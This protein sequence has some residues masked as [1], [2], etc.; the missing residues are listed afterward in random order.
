MPR[1]HIIL[2]LTSKYGKYRK[3]NGKMGQRLEYT[4]PKKYIQMVNKN[5]KN[6]LKV[7]IQGDVS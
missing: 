3:P 7:I 6:K 5:M 1:I 4:L 2:I